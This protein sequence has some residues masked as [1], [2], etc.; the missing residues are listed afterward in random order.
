VFHHSSS[1][2]CIERRPNV[3]AFC[4][5]RNARCFTAAYSMPNNNR[6]ERRSDGYRLE[7][8][9]L[10]VASLWE[11]STRH[12]IPK[13]RNFT[14]R[15]WSD[16]LVIFDASNLCSSTSLYCGFPCARPSVLL[17]HVTVTHGTSDLDHPSIRQEERCPKSGVRGDWYG[18]GISALPPIVLFCPK[19]SKN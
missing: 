14:L 6:Y 3:T 11:D 18:E 2:L 10:S 16:T 15:I 4:H 9:S 7:G 19:K 12:G 1:N 5:H 17:L 13:A 8:P